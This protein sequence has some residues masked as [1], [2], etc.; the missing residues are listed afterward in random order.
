MYAVELTAPSL[1]SFGFVSGTR[2][3]VDLRPIISRR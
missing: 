3:E 1:S 2:G